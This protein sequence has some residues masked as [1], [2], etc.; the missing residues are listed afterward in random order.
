MLRFYHLLRCGSNRPNRRAPVQLRFMPESTEC[1]WFHSQDETKHM[2]S[3][4]NRK[5]RCR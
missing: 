4:S 3:W 1:T 5:V 2:I